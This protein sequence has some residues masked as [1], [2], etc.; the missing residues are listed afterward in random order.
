MKKCKRVMFSALCAVMM[1]IGTISAFAAEE[2]AVTSVSIS[3]KS[4]ITAG[5]NGDVEVTSRSSK[6]SC[7]SFEWVNEP[8]E[9]EVGDI[10]RIRIFI[11][12]EDGYYFDKVSGSSKVNISGADFVSVKTI[13]NKSTLQITAKLNP[14]E[15]TLD[16]PED[17]HWETDSI[18]L[19]GRG[20]WEKSDNAGGYEIRLYRDDKRVGGVEKVTGTMYQFYPYMT[21]AGSYRFS[22]RAVPSDSQ[23]KYLTESDWVDSDEMDVHEDNVYNAS[24]SSNTGAVNAQSKGWHS[25]SRGRWYVRDDGNYTRDAWEYVNGKWYLFDSEGYM[26]TGWQQRNGYWYYL[27]APNGD[28][29]ANAWVGNYY[30]TASGE[31]LPSGWVKNDTGWWYVKDNGTY[32]ANSWEYINGKWYLFDA[33]GY[34]LTGWHNRYEKWY[35]LNEPN[36]D[37]AADTWVGGYYVNGDGVRTE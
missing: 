13:D 2:K 19:F 14:V 5:S 35:Y 8:E 20:S 18:N 11:V 6:Y 1:V 37:M 30:V 23:E 15:G 29:A 28:M 24:N 4:S 26:L 22:V 34:M 33:Q 9:W 25:N 17:P 21:K 36:G 10:P 32:A 3:V 16:E 12:A 7:N 31:W 27:I